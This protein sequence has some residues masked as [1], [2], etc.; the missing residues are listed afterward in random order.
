MAT[1]S[2]KPSKDSPRPSSGARPRPAGARG[3][4]KEPRSG[5]RAAPT[6]GGPCVVC[7]EPTTQPGAQM[8]LSCIRKSEKA[9]RP[10]FEGGA[11]TEHGTRVARAVVCV[12]CGKEDHVAFKP[13]EAD[14]VMCRACTLEVAGRDE[15]GDIKKPGFVDIRCSQCGRMTRLLMSVIKK[16]RKDADGKPMPPVCGDCFMG[17]EVNKSNKAATAERRRPGVLLKRREG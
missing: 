2:S 10:R 14:K 9:R 11:R 17:I 5:P 16:P 1:S 3:P 6:P 13:R 15:H 8:C 4:K 12:R 7:G